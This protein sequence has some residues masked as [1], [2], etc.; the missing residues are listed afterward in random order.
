MKVISIIIPVYNEETFVG[1]L[2][3]KVGQLDFSAL[4][5]EKELIIVNDGSK[6]G[7]HDRINAFLETYA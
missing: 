3:E 2:L 6:D 7:S 5:Y 4:G 1:Q